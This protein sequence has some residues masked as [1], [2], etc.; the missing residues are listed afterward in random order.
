MFGERKQQ[1]EEEFFR[2]VHSRGAIPNEMGRTCYRA[3][4]AFKQSADEVCPPGRGSHS[5]GVGR[6]GRLRTSDREGGVHG[7]EVHVLSKLD[8]SF[9]LR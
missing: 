1:A 8:A 6:G 4:L 9:M 3:I 7:G 5:R 2:I